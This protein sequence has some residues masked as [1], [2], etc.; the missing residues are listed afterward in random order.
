[1]ATTAAPTGA[2]TA[3]SLARHTVLVTVFEARNF[4][5]LGA[6]ARAQVRCAFGDD[7]LQSG[8][9]ACDD[10]APVWDTEMAWD[11]DGKILHYL[12][13][14]RAGLKL[15]FQLVDPRTRA[16]VHVGHVVLDL[17]GSPNFPP[18]ERWV[19]LAGAARSE[20]GRPEVRL[21]FGVGVLGDAVAGSVTEAA[22]AVATRG[23]DRSPQ[24]PPAWWD[25][26]RSAAGA[27]PTTLPPL[28][29]PAPVG[30]SPPRRAAQRPQTSPPRAQHTRP[31]EL[32]FTVLAADDGVYELIPPPGHPALSSPEDRIE[33][34]LRIGILSARGLQ[35]LVADPTDF[36]QPNAYSLSID[37]LGTVVR[38]NVFPLP[39]TGSHATAP[40]PPEHATVRLRASP[41]AL[42]AWLPAGLGPLAVHLRRADRSS[43]SIAEATVP[44]GDALASR[45]DPSGGGRAELRGTYPLGPASV[46]VS[47]SLESRP[48]RFFSFLDSDPPTPAERAPTPPPPT[49]AAPHRYRLTLDLR[50]LRHFTP[51]TSVT[52]TARHPLLPPREAAATAGPDGA[53]DLPASR[54]PAARELPPARLES[55]LSLPLEIEASVGGRPLG[56]ATVRAEVMSKGWVARTVEGKEVRSRVWDAWVAVGGGEAR[57]AIGV[58]DFGPVAEPRDEGHA[59]APARASHHE[60]E[61]V[62]VGHGV[63]RHVERKGRRGRKDEATGTEG[64]E[65]ASAGELVAAPAPQVDVAPAEEARMHAP[66]PLPRPRTT[67]GE[68][69]RAIER[70]MRR[71]AEAEAL[72]TQLQDRERAVRRAE[73]EAQRVLV[74]LERER[75]RQEREWDERARRWDET[76]AH[77]AQLERARLEAA[78]E[79]VRRAEREREEAEEGRRRCEREMARLQ[80]RV[81]EQQ[82]QL[83]HAQAPPAP[84]T[85]D[86]G[87]VAAAAASAVASAAEIARLAA[88]LR[89]SELRCEELER[90]LEREAVVSRHYRARY[91]AV[92]GRLA[93]HRRA[94]VG[95]TGRFRPAASTGSLAE[96]P[97]AFAAAHGLEQLEDLRREL[98]ELRRSAA[99]RAEAE[100]RPVTRA[101]TETRSRGLDGGSLRDEWDEVFGEEGVEGVEGDETGLEGSDPAAGDATPSQEGELWC[102]EP[103]S[104]EDEREPESA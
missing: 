94:A 66:P 72:H 43:L 91:A 89:R 23:A 70:R 55:L 16:A 93:E 22:A 92:A 32:P 50:S 46:E 10:G 51:C 15:S 11:V 49:D 2:A 76:R 5:R 75:E 53:A 101:N 44:A 38:T 80:A 8:F 19:P 1:M 12:R 79:R 30:R 3:R 45:L 65:R 47:I 57:V 77:A 48:R 63:A 83:L 74:D 13:T 96:D 33:Y 88:E 71:L 14:H 54:H 95:V 82:H 61:E 56:T 103:F 36:S 28:P 9:A 31:A 35:R 34:T 90:R 60:A 104:L 29:P 99:G 52:L 68:A 7:A 62:S 18:P 40:F 27:R 41:A 69:A 98:E 87:A 86:P 78:E 58:D 102:A 97:D 39:R 81:L 73:D 17:R 85:A 84:R 6:G 67:S 100:R 64:E 25:A 20:W 26:P 24:P 4:P 21:A 42:L 59:H 37:L